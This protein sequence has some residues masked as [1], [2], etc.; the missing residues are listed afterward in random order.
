[1]KD[2]TLTN[3]AQKMSPIGNNNQPDKYRAHYKKK[4]RKRNYCN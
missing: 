1:M 4:K 3:V 2:N